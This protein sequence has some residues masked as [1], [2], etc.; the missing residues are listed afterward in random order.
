M[1]HYSSSARARHAEVRLHSDHSQTPFS[2]PPAL[3]RRQ[4]KGMF[5]DYES[6]LV[7]EEAQTTISESDWSNVKGYII[8]F[9]GVSHPNMVHAAPGDPSRLA[10]QEILEEEQ[11]QLDHIDDVFPMCH[12]IMKIVRADIDEDIFPYG[13]VSG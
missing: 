7:P 12:R 1:S 5:D 10:H 9:F 11:A 3:T 6:H 8:W 13:M 4:I 2:A